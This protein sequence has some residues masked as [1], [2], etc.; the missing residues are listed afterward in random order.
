MRNHTVAVIG[1]GP[2]GY[3]TAIRLKQYGIDTVVFEK[4][5]L[6]G[7]CLNWGCI[8]TKTLVKSAELFGEMKRADE[9]GLI[10]DAPKVNYEKVYERKN[11]VVNQLVSGVEFLFKKRKIDVVNDIVTKVKKNDEGYLITT[12]KDEKALVKY[13]ILATGSEPVELPFMKFDGK[14]IL[15]S[16]DVLKMTDL[17]ESMVVVGGGVVGCEFASIFHEFGVNVEIVEFLPNLVATENPDVSKRLAMAF[18]RSKMKLHLKTAVEGCEIVDGKAV[19]ALSNGK[20]ITTDSVLV[21][22]G[23]R[24]TCNIE[25]VNCEL[26]WDNKAVAIDDNFKTNIPN[27]FAI[28]DLTGKMQLAHT[29]SKQ[30]LMTAEIIKNELEGKNLPEEKLCYENIPRCIFTHPEIGSV[31]LTEPQAKEK[32]EDII[33][34]SFQFTGVGKAL[35]IGNTFGFVKVIADKATHKLV[36]MHIIGPNATELIAEGGILIQTETSIEEAVKVVYAHPTLSEAVMESIEDLE[37][38][39]IHKV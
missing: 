2:G 30:G 26:N 20:S 14:H 19:L 4:E 3:V 29:A 25:F 16:R 7:V 32:Y 5:R 21:S 34:G 35:G 22:V 12:E 38:L 31:G 6:G 27:V 18:K 15:S 11:K 36:G 8:P 28:G 1:G 39:A 23:R 9:F 10:C 37:G 17:P 13:I 33:I 24:A